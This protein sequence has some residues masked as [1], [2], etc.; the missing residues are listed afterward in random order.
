[1][2]TVKKM[3]MKTSRA[4]KKRRVELH[5]S[6]HVTYSKPSSKGT[7]N[8][9]TSTRLADTRSHRRR[10]VECGC[11]TYGW[12]TTCA[13]LEDDESV[14]KTARSTSSVARCETAL[15]ANRTLAHPSLPLLVGD[16][17]LEPLAPTDPLP[18]LAFGV[19]AVAAVAPPELTCCTGRSCSAESAEPLPAAL[20]APP[21]RTDVTRERGLSSPSAASPRVSSSMSSTPPPVRLLATLLV[22][23]MLP[24]A[25]R[26]GTRDA[27]SDPRRP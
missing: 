10:R 23:R 24:C 6:Q 18:V 2:S 13:S 5:L 15:M 9:N 3:S 21:L 4:K 7:Q 14:P 25:S 20:P 19:P 11:A 22:A 12:C 17:T 1:M 8:S 16:A 27:K 26:P